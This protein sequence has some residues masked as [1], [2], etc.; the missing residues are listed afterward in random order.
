MDHQDA[1]RRIL[2]DWAVE[3][4]PDGGTRLA[5]T[6][7]TFARYPIRCIL[8]IY[9][10]ALPLAIVAEFF[11]NRR[12]L[13][14]DRPPWEPLLILA[15]SVV[16]V[17][18]LLW[19]G[20]AITEYRLAA[21]SLS[22]QRIF[23]G[24][25]YRTTP[26]TG[27]SLALRR[28]MERGEHTWSLVLEGPGPPVLLITTRSDFRKK[29]RRPRPLWERWCFGIWPAPTRWLVRMFG[30]S[31]PYD[32]DELAVLAGLVSRATD[33]PVRNWDVLSPPADE[34]AE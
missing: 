28:G 31:R 33:W 16:A 17:G 1:G 18:L 9:S 14:F 3:P 23:A 20:F 21:D 34:A 24:L 15:C 29:P 4:Q 11:L 26:Y 13:P 2:E 27:A 7:G 5:R 32:L 22:V 25:V 10:L 30:D 6:A 19:Q 12:W 8:F